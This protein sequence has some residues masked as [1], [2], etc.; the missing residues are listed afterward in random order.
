MSFQLTSRHDMK[1][2][3]VEMNMNVS[4]SKLTE[5][6]HYYLLHNGDCLE[7]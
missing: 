7:G 6:I 5:S 1:G 4:K 2:N 3:L